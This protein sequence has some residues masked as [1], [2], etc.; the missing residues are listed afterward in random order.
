MATQPRAVPSTTEQSA[1]PKQKRRRSPSVAKPAFFVVQVLDE[2]GQPQQ[3]DK[4][5]LKIISV[6]RSAEQVMELVESGEHP[7]AFYLR[8]IVPVARTQQTRNPAPAA[9][10]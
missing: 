6:E 1:A 3:F 8:G 9:A 5:R 7:Y 2:S 4:K 10:E